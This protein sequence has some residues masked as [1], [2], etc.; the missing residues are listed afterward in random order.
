MCYSKEVQLITSL[1]I[2]I[3]S[4]GY[5][6]YFTRLYQ[7]QNKEWLLPFL[8]YLLFFNL[9][10]GF[11]QF[12]EFLSLVTEN[13]VIYKV[14]LLLSILSTYFLLRSL[15]IL[16]RKNYHSVIFLVIISMVGLY[17]FLISMSFTSKSFYLQH[18]SAFIWAAAWLLF[19]FYWHFCV[20]DARKELK[21]RTSR[22]ML[23]K[24]LFYV[25]E[26]SFL[27]SGIYVIVGYFFHS[28]NVCYDSPSIWCTFSTIQV[29]FIPFFLSTLHLIHKK[30][31]KQTSL[32]LQTTVWFFLLSLIIVAFLASLLPLFN[33]LSWKFIFP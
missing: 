18:Y 20:F 22:K 25:T 13:Q 10:I 3:V 15:E 19:F 7:Q 30:P 28:V 1:I 31:L 26:I 16:V 6:L 33:C 5:Y 12:F 21:D 11:H 8:K 32:P 2:I 24:Y 27:L 9:G 4:L 23:L 14:G 29:L 17:N